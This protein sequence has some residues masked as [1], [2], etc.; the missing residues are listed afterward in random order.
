VRSGVTRWDFG[1]LPRQ[2]RFRQAGLDI[3]SYPAL[4]EEGDG[5]A[6]ILCDY[7]GEALLRHRRGVLRLLRLHTAQQVKYLRKELLRGNEFNLV[8]AGAGFDR[9]ALLEDLVDA[10][11]MQ[12]ME[13][14]TQLPFAAAD[15]EA[16]LE[17]GRGEVI[18]RAN[19]LAA[20][21]L[22]AL[23]LLSDIR[24]LRAGLAAGRWPDTL[25]DV[26]QQLQRLL[27][28]GFLRDTPGP[29][30][31]QLPRYL[32]ALRTRL[33]RLPGQYGKDQGHTAML[34]ELGAPLWQAVAERDG[35]LLTCAAAGQYRWQL[36][37]FRVSLFAQNLGT[38]LPVSAKRLQAQWRDVVQWLKQNPH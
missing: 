10:S 4:T 26:D 2:W 8:L 23:R 15:F 33:E 13:V 25:A 36:E 30:L 31:S 14:D 34:A 6:V 7:P 1:D 38:R 20:M 28:A 9:G 11:Y 32:K 22:E 5:A 24:R 18:S 35:L 37:E 17:R 29:W 3:V 21:L 16:M 19:S 27:A 12:A